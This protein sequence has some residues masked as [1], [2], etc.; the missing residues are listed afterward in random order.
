MNMEYRQIVSV[1]GLAGLYQL[2]GTKKDGAIVKSLLDDTVKFISARV[3]HLTPLESIEIYTNDENVRLHEVFEM[4][5]ENDG[6]IETLT[7]KKD[8]KKAKEYFKTIL[9]NYDED[10]VYVSDIKK[11]LKWYV[12]LKEKNLLDFE[13]LKEKEETPEEENETPEVVK[14]EKKEKATKKATTAKKVPE[15]KEASVQKETKEKKEKEVK[16]TV[17]KSDKSKGE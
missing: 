10:R 2:I 13:Y 12:I 7:G 3:H 15:V 16:K 1:T 8:D 5:K 9:P 14:E 6:E 4:I 17:K 11:I